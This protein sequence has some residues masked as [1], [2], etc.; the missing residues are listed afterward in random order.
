[1]EF[2]ASLPSISL[3]LTPPESGPSL[4]FSQSTQARNWLFTRNQLNEIRS[5]VYNQ[6]VE[7]LS[8]LWIQ[9]DQE[10]RLQDGNGN[11]GQDSFKPT[12][13]DF[14]TIQQCQLLIAFYLSKIPPIVRVFNKPTIVETTAI[15][16][17]K[18][19]YCNFTPW[20]HNV[21]DVM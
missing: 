7:S 2:Q 15:S 12:R 14:P 4:T 5:Q 16:Y 8:N 3:P 10:R 6:S 20:Q 21:K 13:L 19:F 1:M 11:G 9:E 18:R 17:L